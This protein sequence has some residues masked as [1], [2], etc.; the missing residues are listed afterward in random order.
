TR[1]LREW[2]VQE[3]GVADWLVDDSYAHVGD[4]AETLT[5][6]LDDTSGQPVTLSL[7]QW[8]EQRLLPVAGGD[9]AARRA[10]VLDAWRGLV[11]D[12]RLVFNKLLTG[13]LR[14]GVSQRLVQ[15]ALA[16]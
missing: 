12:E 6:L 15:Q 5:L 2:I 14:V 1:E 16:E 11:C 7:S 13:S 9:L 4:L 8:I 3:S 10:T